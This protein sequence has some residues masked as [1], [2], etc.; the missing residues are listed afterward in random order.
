MATDLTEE[1]GGLTPLAVTSQ[2]GG[3]MQSGRPAAMSAPGSTPVDPLPPAKDQG[4]PSVGT[5][6]G[7]GRTHLQH[8]GDDVGDGRGWDN[9]SGRRLPWGPRA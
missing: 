6:P 8:G 9:V 2:A 3:N 5:S 4:D 7:G 1:Y